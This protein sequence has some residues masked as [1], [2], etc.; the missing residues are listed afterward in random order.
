M[1]A[2]LMPSGPVQQLLLAFEISLL[3]MGGFLIFRLIANESPRARWLGTNRLPH[4]P[5]NGTE[6]ALFLLLVIGCGFF[7]QT[8]AQI[9]LKGYIATSSS[10]PGLEIFVYGTGF[11]GGALLGWL[12]F[13]L[14]RRRWH[15]EYGAPPPP[16]ESGPRPAWPFPFFQ[17]VG[18][19]LTA[20]P[21]L[22]VF[23]LGWTALLQKLGL[24]DEPQDLIA[25]FAG[26]KSPLVLTGMLL[27]ACGLAPLNE[28]LIF[29]AGL[30]R[31]CR[32]R[33]G[34]SWAF[35]ISG[36][37]FGALHAN[38]ASFLPLGLLGVA[39][40]VAYEAT[41]DIRVPVIAHAL[42][43]LNTIVVVLA[44]LPQ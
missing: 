41:G 31:F 39:L 5:V 29:R 4:W 13:P 40:A 17:G 24:P 11:H 1:C 19:L 7:L 20:L 27:V 22:I 44:G 10:R 36:I 42:F 38:W 8:T 21:L 34:R 16:E 6:F 32:Q 12:L 3:L 30:Y 43:N 35:V 9:L 37:C 25:I 14:L 28:E 18:V 15:G 2:S 33:L 23:N 26:T